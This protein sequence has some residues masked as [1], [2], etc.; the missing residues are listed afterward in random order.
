MPDLTTRN[1]LM[2]PNAIV[3]DPPPPTAEKDTSD[4]KT[5]RWGEVFGRIVGTASNILFPNPGSMLGSVLRGSSDA[6]QMASFQRVMNQSIQH[7]WNMV[8]V[9]KQVQDQ[10]LQVSM[11]S[12]LLKSRHVGHMAA[13][14]N[15]NS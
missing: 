15:I 13:V 8:Q 9:Q 12:N 7:S 1:I 14:Q 5:S 3:D 2:I 11:I 4:K 10:S 6:T